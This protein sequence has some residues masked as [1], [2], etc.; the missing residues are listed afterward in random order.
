MI[1]PASISVTTVTGERL[2]FS[3]LQDNVGF[4]APAVTLQLMLLALPSE[5]VWFLGDTLI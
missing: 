2:L 5:T 1:D 3:K 4:G